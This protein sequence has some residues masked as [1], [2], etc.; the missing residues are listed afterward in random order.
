MELSLIG[1]QNA[2]KTSLVNVIATGGY[3]EDMIPTVGFNMRKVM[4]GN[5]T[6]KLW[7]LGG[8]PRFR[9]MWERYCRAVSAIVYTIYSIFSFLYI[10]VVDA[11]DQDN[12][13]ISKREL[14]DLLSKQSLSGIPLL[15]V[16][17]K[18]DKPQVVS[19]QELTDQMARGMLLYDLVQ[20][21]DEYRPGQ[22][23]LV[24]SL[25]ME[26]SAPPN[27]PNP[28][29]QPNLEATKQKLLKHGIQPTP[30]ILHTLR[31]KELQKSNRR[32]AKEATKQPLPLTDSQ[33]IEI[34]EETQFQIIKSEYKKFVK[35]TKESNKLVGLPWEGLEKLRLRE[36]AS[37]N[38]EYGGDKLKPEH[39][40]ELSDIIEC[41]RDK[42]S[43]LL[44]DDVEIEDGWFVENGRGWVPRKRS[45]AESIKLSETELRMKD[46]KF[47]RMMRQT[48]LQFTEGQ[49]LKIVEGLGDRG[50]WSHALSVVEW[51]YNSKEFRQYKSRFVYTKLLAV[52]GRA[53]KP[54]ESLRVFNLMRGDAYIYPDIAAYH[55]LAVTLGQAGFLKELVTVI[56][57]MKLKPKKIRNVR[58]KSWDPVLQPDIVI[59]N[60]VLNACVRTRQWKG[61]SWVFQQL[62]K[63]GLRPNG[64]SYGLAME[65]M[66]QSEKYDL[67]HAFF[68]KMKRSGEALNAVTYKVLVKAFWKEGKVNEAVQA[69]RDMERRG[70]IG[71]ASVYYELA[72]CLSY[73]GKWTEAIVEIEKLR[74]LRPTRPLAITFS[75]VILS[76]MNGGHVQDCV[77]IFEHS[78]SLLSPDIG[79]IN[80][81]LKV[82]G[83]N[84]MFYEA[85][86]LFEETRRNSLVL[87]TSVKGQ[88]SSPKP[89]SYTFG[90]MLEASASAQQWEFFDY[91]YKEMTLSGEQIDFTKH[92]ASLL[93]AS[94][95]GKWH[96]LEHA[97]DS[98]LEAGEIP[99]VSFFSEMVCQATARSDYERAVSIINSMAYAPFKVGFEQWVN[100]FEKNVDMI[101]RAN[102]NELQEILVS[103]DLVQEATVLNLSRALQYICRSHDKGLKIGPDSANNDYTCGEGSNDEMHGA[104]MSFSREDEET[105]ERAGVTGLVQQFLNDDPD[106]DISESDY[107]DQ[108]LEDVET[109]EVLSDFDDQESDHVGIVL[110]DYDDQESDHVGNVEIVSDVDDFNF[111][112]VI[113]KRRD[114]SQEFG[115]PSAYEILESWKD[116][117]KA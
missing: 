8:Q 56:E 11:A 62:R 75:G 71:I 59:F 31:K 100:I 29:R 72:R 110:S 86:E 16:G 103:R 107:D 26:A 41:E 105:K 30:K 12:I 98:I 25:P 44:V 49:M 51:L 82:Y 109:G 36:L 106:W 52:L 4:K 38:F 28:P 78:R 42:F 15:V 116:K 73:Y 22:D 14:H 17:N 10:Y 3:S 76:A 89:D 87:D 97:F 101:D 117:R 19:K 5:V 20:E 37:H 46:W 104:K 114:D 93:E 7:D 94:Q 63:N 79:I 40:R 64:A 81:M 39:L 55:S 13:V 111:E 6:M 58:H 77:S 34:A 2:G 74:V 96:L 108:E 70:V 18:T 43:W 9:S 90:S 24:W 45:E 84:D 91:V 68:E 50:Q 1:L 115:M 95:A 47:S 85:K 66:L 69:V 92:S 83:Q 60:A 102:L 21:L 99:P 113:P 61:V 33:K 23:Y 57:Y 112:L 32:L 88:V 54:R 35:S 27:L 65:V 53:G 48:G 67:V 80:A